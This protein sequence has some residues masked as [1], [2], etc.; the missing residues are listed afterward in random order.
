MWANYLVS[1]NI[2]HVQPWLLIENKQIKLE[3]EKKEK[4]PRKYSEYMEWQNK[5]SKSSDK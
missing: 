1:L 2:G 4:K 3:E 5:D